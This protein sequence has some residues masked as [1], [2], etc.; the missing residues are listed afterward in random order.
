MGELSSAYKGLVRK[1]EWKRAL[2][3]PV[4]RWETDCKKQRRKVLA[5]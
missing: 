2:G 4:R 1:L 5:G 3:R